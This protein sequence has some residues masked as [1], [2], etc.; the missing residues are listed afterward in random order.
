MRDQFE[1]SDSASSSAPLKILYTEIGRGHPFYLDGIHQALLKDG[2]IRMVRECL[3]VFGIS[4]GF[5]RASWQ[6]ARWLYH[7]GSSGGLA[8]VIY[9]RL[10]KGTDYNK[11]SVFLDLMGRDI[12]AKLSPES[13]P[14]I[15]AHPTLVAI[16]KGRA[17]LIYQHG[18]LITPPEAV[19]RGAELVIVPTPEAGKIFLD[20]G[21]TQDHLFVSGLCI[22]LPLVAQADECYKNR[23]NRLQTTQ[24]LTGAFFSSGAEPK[25]HL[26]TII[27]SVISIIRN[28]HR[29]IIF[30]REHG[31]LISKLTGALDKTTQPYQVIDS[32][33]NLPL[34][35]EGAL[36]VSHK[37]RREEDSQTSALFRLFD[38]FMAPSHERANWACGLG[39]PM[40]IAGP[41]IGPFAPLN[42][43]FLLASKV[44]CES[45]TNDFSGSLNKLHSGGDLSQMAQL[46]YGKYE[47]DGFSKTARF[48]I[49]KY[50]KKS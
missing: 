37:N 16:L 31:N 42:R 36:I 29:A 12:K 7:N 25:S 8:G 4:R 35:F 10:R 17:G 50:T 41:P 34:E 2:Q 6:V 22:E 23:I 46:G 33:D 1:T 32:T 30:A 14:L 45:D 44:A 19:V 5:S 49:N 20:S 18:E 24:K 39:L 47:I 38:F 21:Y 27:E 40:F 13:S 9:N 15:V 48:L 11:G 26:R 3:D 28:E 43:D